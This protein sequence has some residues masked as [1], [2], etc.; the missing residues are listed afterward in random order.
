MS[1][2]VT[3]QSDLSRDPDTANWL[4]ESAQLDFNDPLTILLQREAEAEE[5]LQ[6]FV[7]RSTT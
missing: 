7:P 4:F 5:D 2:L 1:R 3:N 6:Y